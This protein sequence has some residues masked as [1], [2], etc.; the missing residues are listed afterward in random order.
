MCVIPENIPSIFE[1]IRSNAQVETLN[2]CW[3]NKVLPAAKQFLAVS[4]K[5]VLPT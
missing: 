1:T 4:I 3:V 2:E 5:F